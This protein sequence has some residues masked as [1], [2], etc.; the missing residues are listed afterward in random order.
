MSRGIES[1]VTHYG[2][3]ICV[4]IDPNDGLTHSNR[5]GEW[6]EAVFARNDNLSSRSDIISISGCTLA[7]CLEQK[8][9]KYE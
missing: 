9:A 5:N 8:Q 2:V 7:V 4:V 3:V 1:I 6:S